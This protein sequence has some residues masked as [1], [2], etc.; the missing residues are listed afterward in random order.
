LL[1][2]QWFFVKQPDKHEFN[3]IKSMGRPD[4]AYMDSTS[5]VPTVHVA[6]T[7]AK[8]PSFDKIDK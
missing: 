1:R 5:A 3:F 8:P 7:P 2:T 6:E 4:L